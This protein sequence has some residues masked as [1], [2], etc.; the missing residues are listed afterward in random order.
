MRALFAHKALVL[1]MVSMGV[2]LAGADEMSTGKLPKAVIDRLRSRFPQM[3]IVAAEQSRNEERDRYVVEIKGTD[4]PFHVSMSAAGSISQIAYDGKYVPGYLALPV[5][6]RFPHAEF[7]YATES[8]DS[9][10]QSG[11]AVYLRYEKH[12]IIAYLSF[13]GGTGG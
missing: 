6:H 13:G 8:D 5:E 11:A 1:L 4:G 7:V 10:L 2:S 3:E 12:N 9:S